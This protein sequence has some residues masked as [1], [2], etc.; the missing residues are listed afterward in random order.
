MP[1]YPST[2]NNTGKGYEFFNIGGKK[3][4]TS[5]GTGVAFKDMTT[6][7][8]AHIVR[9]L[10]IKSRPNAVID[11]DPN[12]DNDMIFLFDRY[13]ETE[14]VYF[15]KEEVNEKDALMHKRI[16]ELSHIGDIPH[17]FPLQIPFKLAAVVIQIGLTEEKAMEILHELNHIPKKITGSQR[18]QIIQRLHDAKEW[19]DNFASDDCKFEIQDTISSEARKKIHEQINEKSKKALQKIAGVIDDKMESK[20]LHEKCY[21]IVTELGLEPKEFFKDAYR[22]IINKDRGPQL[23][24]F[25]LTIGK[26]RFENIIKQI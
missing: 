5:K 22:V 19:I 11:F 20:A 4:S 1:P 18:H 9:Y 24:S 26:K 3:M 13:D 6:V 12:R 21:E 2:K 10:L 17:E 8:P 14:R 15:G 23:A 25:I 16:Y 7:L